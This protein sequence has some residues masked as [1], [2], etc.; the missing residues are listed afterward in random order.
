MIEISNQNVSVPSTIQNTEN[1]EQFIK[2]D[3]IKKLNKK[4]L[5]NYIK[6]DI[7]SVLNQERSLNMEKSCTFQE[8]K[9]NLLNRIL[10][11]SEEILQ[12]EIFSKINK[13]NFLI[14]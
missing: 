7:S 4:N 8:E 9:E 1:L 2:I 5:Q 10:L 6:Q 12:E 13:K 14:N 3:K 11:I